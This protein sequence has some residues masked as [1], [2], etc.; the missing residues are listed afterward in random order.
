[1]LVAAPEPGVRSARTYELDGCVVFRYPVPEFAT[2]DEA[3]GDVVVRGAEHLHDWLREVRAD[4]VHVHTFVTGLGLQE[5]L[6]AKRA[7]IPSGSNSY[8]SI[9]DRFRGAFVLANVLRPQTER[10]LAELG[11][12]YELTLLSGDNAKERTIF[13]HLF[14]E[15]PQLLFNQSP[16]EKLGIIEGLKRS[17]RT[18]MM[19][20]DGLNDAGAL[21]QSDVGVAVVEQIGHFSPASDIILEASQVSNLFRILAFAR[22]TTRVVRL[23][24]GISAGYNLIGIS[25]ASAG[26]L[27]PLV[28]AVLMP[29]S[30]ISVVMFACGMTTWA[31]SRA[32]LGSVSH[33]AED[34]GTAN[35]PSGNPVLFPAS[36]PALPATP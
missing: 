22:Q 33:P 3:Q 23:S 31:A 32:G 25:I 26:I 1:M 9:D 5:I 15:G 11:S 28:C 30:S 8:L 2:R 35:S 34:P 17:G 12:R 21:R 29:L 13:A 10:L 18:V 7:G 6:A 4:V 36:N 14:G 16:V 27:S 20:G 24:F 19:V